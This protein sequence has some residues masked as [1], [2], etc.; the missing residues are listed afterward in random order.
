MSLEARE[1]APLLSDVREHVATFAR[2]VDASESRLEA[3]VA[4][5]IFTE[6]ERRTTT[7]TGKRY[8]RFRDRLYE[9]NNE[10]C[11]EEARRSLLHYSN[12]AIA[13]QRAEIFEDAIDDLKSSAR[14]HDKKFRWAGVIEAA[15]GA[16]VWTGL[17]I[18]IS[19]ILIYVGIDILEV[20]G[21]VKGVH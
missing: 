13:K 14:L 18:V 2:F 15:F 10:F 7:E 5:G 19:W 8:S 21:R 4:F 6:F 20:F 1:P 17:L 9:F 11:F 12:E 16:F 3:L